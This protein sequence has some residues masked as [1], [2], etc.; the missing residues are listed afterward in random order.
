VL[1]PQGSDTLPRL[2]PNCRLLW[3]HLCSKRT[4]FNFFRVQFD[5]AVHYIV[6]SLSAYY[7]TDFTSIMSIYAKREEVKYTEIAS[8]LSHCLRAIIFISILVIAI[9]QSLLNHALHFT[10]STVFLLRFSGL[11]LSALYRSVVVKDLSVSWL[12][13][14][15]EANCILTMPVEL[16]VQI[17]HWEGCGNK[18][19]AQTK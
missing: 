10:F 17:E 16:V 1:L 9:R 5:V 3:K 19:V 12:R 14:R 13:E 8:F 7:D 4:H 2:L 11:T 15:T 18:K 6:F